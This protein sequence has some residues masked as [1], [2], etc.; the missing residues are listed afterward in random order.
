[1]I[2]QFLSLQIVVINCITFLEA[3]QFCLSCCVIWFSE[4][5]FLHLDSLWLLISVA[6][7]I[8]LFRVSEHL[9]FLELFLDHTLNDTIVRELALQ[10]H[11][12]FANFPFVF[13][14]SKLI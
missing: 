6:I 14:F 9:I 7:D 3:L 1:M 8:V 11:E 2:H 13:R 10:G 12:L 4:P 5:F